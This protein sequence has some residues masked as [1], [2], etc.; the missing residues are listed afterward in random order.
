M[1]QDCHSVDF[2]RGPGRYRV[3]GKETCATLKFDL[4]IDRIEGKIIARAGDAAYDEAATKCAA[5]EAVTLEG[6]G[7][8]KVNVPCAKTL[9]PRPPWLGIDR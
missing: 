2:D 7:N 5:H 1:R 9:D 4:E 6:P 3:H 8:V